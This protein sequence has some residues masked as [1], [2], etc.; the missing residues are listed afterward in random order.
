[1]NFSNNFETIKELIRCHNIDVDKI[2]LA[3]WTNGWTAL[4]YVSQYG[5]LEIVKELIKSGADVNKANN[6]GWTPLMIASTYA[7]II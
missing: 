7:W 4:L 2:S 1:M 3:G 6:S 5:N